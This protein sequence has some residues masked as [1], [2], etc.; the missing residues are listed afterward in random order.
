MTIIHLKGLITADGQLQVTLPPD[1]PEGEVEVT[2]QL[3][4][5]EAAPAAEEEAPWTDEEIRAMINPQ[6]KTGAEIVALL[7]EMGGEGWDHITDSAAWVEELRRKS[8]E[9]YKW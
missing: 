1:L 5:V 9:R 3:T 4:P 7:K 2:L 6:P 8:Q